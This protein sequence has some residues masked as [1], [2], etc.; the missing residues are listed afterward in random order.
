LGGGE[1]IV[2]DPVF[3]VEEE[4]WLLCTPVRFLALI[5]E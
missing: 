2:Q 3:G 1:D 5:V 4:H